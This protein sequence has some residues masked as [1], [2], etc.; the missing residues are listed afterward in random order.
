[1]WAWIKCGNTRGSR[2]LRGLVFCE[3]SMGS[4][5]QS[6]WSVCAKI[7]G[8]ATKT[9]SERKKGRRCRIFLKKEWFFSF[10][11]FWG[12]QILLNQFI[13]A[14]K[15]YLVCYYL[16]VVEVSAHL[17]HLPLQ[18]I[19][20]YASTSERKKKVRKYGMPGYF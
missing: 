6:Y 5:A 4:P 17:V 7:M 12:L 15:S 14:K 16:K 20:Q 19:M 18:M 11:W 8:V 2:Y 1:M 10:V 13:D 3:V 9:T